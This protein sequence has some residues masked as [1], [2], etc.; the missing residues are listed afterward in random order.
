MGWIRKK[1]SDDKVKGIIIA[2]EYDQKLDYARKVVP[3]WEVFLYE[4][5]F[6]LVKFHRR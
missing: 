2:A 1:M 6:K 4:V 5:N 3:N